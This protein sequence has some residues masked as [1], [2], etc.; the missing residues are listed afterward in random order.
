MLEVQEWSCPIVSRNTNSSFFK[1]SIRR[2]RLSV[3]MA[4]SW[5]ESDWSTWHMCTI[6]ALDNVSTVAQ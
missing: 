2:C 4:R 5:P 1:V 6:S 3:M